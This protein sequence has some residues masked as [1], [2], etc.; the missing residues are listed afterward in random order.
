MASSPELALEEI[1]IVDPQDYADHGYPHDAWTRLRRECPVYWYDRGDDCTPFWAITKHA[2]IVRIS[3]RPTE[4]LN[5]PRLAVFPEGKPVE[6]GPIARHLLN[7]DPPVHADYRKLVS[8]Y[9]TPRSIRRLEPEIR[10]IAQGCL[11]EIAGEGEIDFVERVS[12]PIPLAVLADLLGVPRSDWRLLF[13]W[14]NELVGSGDPEYQQ[15]GDDGRATAQRARQSIFQYFADMVELRRRQPRED[16]VSVLANANLHGAPVPPFELLSYYFLLVIAG[17]ETTRNAMSGGLLALIRNP[18]ELEKLRRDPSLV[19]SA[20]EEIVRWT[21]P[22]IQFCRTATRDF[23]LRDQRIR[24]GEA[25][26]LFYPS[27]NRDEEVFDAPFAFR[28]DRRPNPH[29]AFGIGEHFCLGANLARLELRVLFGE[30]AQRLLSVEQAGPVERLR[31]S[32]LG[33]VKHL[34]VRLRLRAAGA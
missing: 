30:L 14:T 17:N 21:T 6:G 18:D 15:E 27:A 29:L 1:Q 7:M 12:A 23:E 22:V 33:G 8:Q 26:C 28:V 20:V 11:D 16:I 31:S 3:R 9:F 13:R 10:R 34:P 4:H 19:E 5:A 25:M 32:F 2:D 24:A